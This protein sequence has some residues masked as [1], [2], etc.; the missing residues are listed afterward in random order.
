[1]R[2]AFLQGL[3]NTVEIQGADNFNFQL[4]LLDTI[5]VRPGQQVNKGQAIGTQD[6]NL[7]LQILRDGIPV[8]SG[9][10]DTFVADYLN[11]LRGN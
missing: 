7:R 9:I 11:F 2:S 6:N 4:S 3:G 1:V 5:A 10:S 8:D